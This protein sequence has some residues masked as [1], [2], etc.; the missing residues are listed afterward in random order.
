ME[1]HEAHL[2]RRL[3]GFGVPREVGWDRQVQANAMLTDIESCNQQIRS[4]IECQPKD[5]CLWVE[6]IAKRG[7]KGVSLEYSGILY[8]QEEEQNLYLEVMNGLKDIIGD[9]MDQIMGEMARY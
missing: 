3:Q 8:A 4:A 2:E 9:D 7:R 1:T 5:E 6:N